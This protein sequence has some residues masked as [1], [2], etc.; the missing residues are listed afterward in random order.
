MHL[1]NVW[2]RYKRRKLDLEKNRQNIQYHVYSEAK[3]KLNLR[4]VKFYFK[5]KWYEI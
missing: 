4:N 2:N 1:L 5:I 3:T